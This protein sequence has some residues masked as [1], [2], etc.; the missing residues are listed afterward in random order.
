MPWTELAGQRTDF[1]DG[2]L[3]DEA[4]DAHTGLRGSGTRTAGPQKTAS[5]PIYGAGKKAGAS[6]G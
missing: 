4:G 3:L 2:R 1:V 5:G 6:A